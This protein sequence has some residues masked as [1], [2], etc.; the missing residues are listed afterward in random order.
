MLCIFSMDRRFT[1]LQCQALL[2]FACDYVSLLRYKF[3]C[4]SE[5]KA[6]SL[7]AFFLDAPREYVASFVFGWQRFQKMFGEDSVSRNAEVIDNITGDLT[8]LTGVSC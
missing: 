8:F 1:T 6:L 3:A 7:S 4:S 5:G 2:A